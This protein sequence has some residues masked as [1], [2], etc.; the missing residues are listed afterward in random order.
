MQR[1]DGPRPQRPALRSAREVRH[2]AGR[3]RKRDRRFVPE[4][5][6]PWHERACAQARARKALRKTGVLIQLRLVLRDSAAA[7]AA[8]K[9]AQVLR[10]EGFI[11]WR[12]H[13]TLL[14]IG[15][16]GLALTFMD[17]ASNA[18]VLSAALQRQLRKILKTNA[19]LRADNRPG[20]LA[21]VPDTL[22]LV[23]RVESPG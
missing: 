14:L 7:P 18:A 20:V 17:M 19:W 11:V 1:T 8:R 3:Q 2:A 12:D 22:G 6:G 13:A 10:R 23:L 5:A 21:A 16:P 15:E 4:V 9:I